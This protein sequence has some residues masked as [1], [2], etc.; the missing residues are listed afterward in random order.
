M[1]YD[2]VVVPTTGASQYP[3]LASALASRL[4]SQKGDKDMSMEVYSGLYVDES[5]N[6]KKGR[7]GGG[8]AEGDGDDDLDED[9]DD[10]NSPIRKRPSESEEFCISMRKFAI[11]VAIASLLLMFAVVLLVICVLQRRRRRNHH[12]R[13]FGSSGSTIGSG[14][15][16]SGGG[17]GGP[18]SNRAFSR[19]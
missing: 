6:T 14:S 19:D 8:R 13:L 12:R 11:G 17:G 1:G 5:E 3:N 10:V 2:A 9:L 18:Y 4:A 16:Y 15:V 7:G